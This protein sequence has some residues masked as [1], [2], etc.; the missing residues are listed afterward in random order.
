[1]VSCIFS[2]ATVL[3]CVYH[4]TT[5]NTRSLCHKRLLWTIFP[6]PFRV[7]YTRLRTILPAGTDLT[8]YYRS[9]G[10]IIYRAAYGASSDDNWQALL[11]DIHA[12]VIAELT[13]SDATQQPDPIAQQILSLFRLDARSDPRVLNGLTMDE[14]RQAFKDEVGGQ[15]MNAN[16]KE[17]K[18]CLLV[19]EEVIADHETMKNVR[20]HSPWIKCVEVDYVASDHV[21]RH[22]RYGGQRYFSWMKMTTRWGLLRLWTTLG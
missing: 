14:V 8:P 4:N 10:F 6:G 3:L 12:D 22:T 16:H 21:P 20:G 2:G 19:N 15:P 1:V 11:N 7:F 9:F 13:D 5:T 18:Y 17:L